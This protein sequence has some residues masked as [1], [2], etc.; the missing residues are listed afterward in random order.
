M[1]NCKQTL[2]SLHLLHDNL[3]G[4]RKETAAFDFDT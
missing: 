1:K 4:R 3:Y 2:F